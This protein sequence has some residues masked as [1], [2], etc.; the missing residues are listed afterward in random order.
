MSILGN[1]ICAKLLGKSD[2]QVKAVDIEAVDIEA[3]EGQRGR[4]LPLLYCLIFVGNVLCAGFKVQGP[5]GDTVAV[6][7]PGKWFNVLGRHVQFLGF[8]C[9][10]LLQ[11][12]SNMM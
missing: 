4:S 8:S 11:Y 10:V 7:T 6:F 12:V 1:S 3:V 9:S 5:V 2:L